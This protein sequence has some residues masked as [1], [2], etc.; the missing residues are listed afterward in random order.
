MGESFR[1]LRTINPKEDDINN[2]EICIWSTLYVWRELGLS[3]TPKAH[4]F[5]DHATVQMRYIKGGIGEKNSY[6]IKRVY[7]KGIK[8]DQ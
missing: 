8:S 4:I 5:E 3:V 7:Q 1:L 2:C 6:V